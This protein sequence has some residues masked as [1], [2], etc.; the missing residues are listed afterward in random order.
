MKLDYSTL[1]AEGLFFLKD[2]SKLWVFL[3]EDL[4]ITTL[5]LFSSFESWSLSIIF[6]SFLTKEL[7]FSV[8][9]SD[10]TYGY[11]N[12]MVWILV[13]NL[14]SSGFTA[15]FGLIFVGILIFNDSFSKDLAECSNS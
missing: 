11:G 10:G 14:S 12:G 6:K 9:L 13:P 5:I 3:K 2:T 7:K 4:S 1:T 8:S 15:N